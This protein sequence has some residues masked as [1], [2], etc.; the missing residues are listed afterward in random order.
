MV[1]YDDMDDTER[2]MEVNEV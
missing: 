2:E 1:V